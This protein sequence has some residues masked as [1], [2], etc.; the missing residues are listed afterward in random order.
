MFLEK[1]AGTFKEM[2]RIKYSCNFSTLKHE[3][4]CLQEHPTVSKPWHCWHP[5]HTRW[6]QL[7]RF[8]QG[9]LIITLTQFDYG[10]ATIFQRPKVSLLY[11]RVKEPGMTSSIHLNLVLKLTL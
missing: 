6:Q 9:S 2:G 8:G 4:R 5:C 7:P 11:A 3:K 10:G 1:A